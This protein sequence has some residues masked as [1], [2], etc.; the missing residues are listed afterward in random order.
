M[1]AAIYSRKSKFTGKGESIENQIQMCQDYGTKIGIK[2]FLI[3]EDE[4]YSG[5]NMKRPK[6]KEMMKDAKDNK[7][8]VIICYRL[9]RISRN[10]SDFSNTIDI[11]SKYNIEF[12][13]IKEQFDTSTPMGRAMMY[14]SSVFAQLERETIAERI[15]DN[16]FELAKSGRWLGGTPP[17]GFKSE[18]VVYVDE[19]LKEKKLFRLSPIKK[20]LELV[21]FIYDLYFKF[22]S[23]SKV[24][25]QLRQDG[26]RTRNNNEWNIKALQLLLRNPV[27]VKSSDKVISYLKNRGVTVFGEA[28]GCGIL[29]Y[30][31]KDSKDNYKEINEWIYA[32][33]KHEGI[34]NSDFWLKVQYKLDE[35]KSKAPRLIS[36]S[37]GLL[38]GILKCM[39]CGGP[40]YQKTGHIQI[41][42]S[43]AKYYICSNKLKYGSTK[44]RCKNIRS[45]IIEA[46]VIN[47][48]F[49]ITSKKSQLN[50]EIDEYK[51]TSSKIDN[52]KG[53]TIITENIA[54]KEKQIDNLVQQLSLDTSI[55]KYIIPKI[56][57]LN[58]ELEAL[59]NKKAQF[60]NVDTNNVENLDAIDMLSSMLIN[61]KNLYEN[62]DYNRKKYLI[63]SLVSSIYYDSVNY[64]L[65]ITLFTDIK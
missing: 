25:K 48:L 21:T 50:P 23:L 58:K 14:I 32:V 28:N 63:R 49:E 8:Q 29:T 19:N 47:K 40:M 11:L 55:V 44:C 20:E 1:I 34:V 53:I 5:G 4:G 16:M 24:H 22:G 45:D 41:D 37:S 27:Y 31:K 39:H 57:E 43:T 36:D 42:G 38:N 15:R 10:V 61:F 56:E 3:Y 18:P 59:K 46:A 62:S 6:F 26:M 12:V 2:D 13:S 51:A 33:S 54:L 7:F 35:N 30:N 64:M 52:S 9:D 65:A 17:F 60:F